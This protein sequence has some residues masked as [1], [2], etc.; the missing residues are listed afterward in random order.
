MS[1]AK[2]PNTTSRASDP[3]FAAI[4]RHKAAEQAYGDAITLTDKLENELPPC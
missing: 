4:E 2:N 3:I 1:Q